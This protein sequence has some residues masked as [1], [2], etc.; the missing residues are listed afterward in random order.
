MV[1]LDAG[2]FPKT[3]QALFFGLLDK[4]YCSRE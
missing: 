3:A 2:S 4:V 1:N